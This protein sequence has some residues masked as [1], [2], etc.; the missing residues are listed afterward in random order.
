MEKKPIIETCISSLEFEGGE[1][2]L[3]PTTGSTLCS[4]QQDTF[5]NKS[6]KKALFEFVGT[7]SVNITSPVPDFILPNSWNNG[8]YSGKV[9][10]VHKQINGKIPIQHFLYKYVNI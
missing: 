1:I 10:I 6:P 7:F 5:I 2:V 9:L 3:S 4:A 8:L